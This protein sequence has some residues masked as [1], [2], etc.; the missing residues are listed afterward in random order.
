MKPRLG[1]IGGGQ[2][3]GFLCQ[4]AQRLGIHTTV[5]SN[6]PEGMATRFADVVLAADLDDPT[7]V[8]RLVEQSDVITFELED[9]PRVTL[10]TLA[11]QSQAR[12]YPDP[13]TMRLLQNKGDQ[14]DWLVDNGYPTAP[15]LRFDAGL[16]IARTRAEFGDRFVIKTQRGGYDGLGV[17][18]VRDGHV[19]E[20]YD[21]V[22]IIAEAA[23]NDFTEIAVLVARNAEG[24]CVHYP[25]FQSTFDAGGNVL[26][27]VSCPAS[28]DAHTAEQA[29]VLACDTVARL[30]GVG[31][32][33]IEYFLTPDELLV[34]EIAP[35]VHN[36]GHLT[37][38]ASNVSQFE[39]HVRAVMGLP[40]SNVL[41]VTPSV[42][43]NLL[44]EATIAE[45][46]AT[47]PRIE[48]ESDVAVHWYGK[49]KPRPLRK[50]GHLTALSDSIEQAAA[51]ADDSLRRLQQEAS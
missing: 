20:G 18:V 6:N 19:P 36:V 40:L 11:N 9:V 8:E 4:A 34:N 12:V 14:K 29:A 49:R 1:I 43:D 26:R 48:D 7:A 39:Q 28:I 22:P 27:R 35:R 30:E 42:M 47:E 15:H 32:F 51:L 25:V 33:A 16:D 24:A 23:L 2:L 44:Y 38:E 3:G 13:A 45:A 31:V 10:E 41:T 50:M 46:C 21:D 37:I 17:N 5:L